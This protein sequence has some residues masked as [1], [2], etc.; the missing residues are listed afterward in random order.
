MMTDKTVRL[1]I[2][3]DDDEDLYLIND[4]LSEVVEAKYFH[5]VGRAGQPQQQR[6]LFAGHPTQCRYDENRVYK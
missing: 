1:L 2:V 4:A 3:D 6:Q 5:F